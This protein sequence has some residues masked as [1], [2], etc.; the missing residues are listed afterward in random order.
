MTRV[1]YITGRNFLD[2]FGND[3]LGKGTSQ[4]LGCDGNAFENDLQLGVIS[5]SQLLRGTT[6][7][8][9]QESSEKCRV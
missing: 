7:E 3:P 9:R 2:K 8:T 6:K 1:G 5:L 4:T